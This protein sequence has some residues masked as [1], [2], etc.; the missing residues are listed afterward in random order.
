MMTHAL[1]GEHRSRQ[2]ANYLMHLDQNTAGILRVESNWPH[3]RVNFAPLLRPV[4]TDFFG[5][6]D[7]TTFERAGPLDIMRH[8]SQGGVDVAGVEGGVGCAEE[9]DCGCRLALH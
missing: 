8:E 7:K 3:M 5:P 6:T 2:V 4:G 9:W 1:V